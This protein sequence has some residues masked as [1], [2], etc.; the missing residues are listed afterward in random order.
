MMTRIAYIFA[1]TALIIVTGF[2]QPVHA[3]GKEN[4]TV[5]YP[6]DTSRM[7]PDYM[8]AIA[9]ANP[10]ETSLKVELSTDRKKW[11][12]VEVPDQNTKLLAVSSA[13]KK[14]YCI[15]STGNGKTSKRILYK[16]R[17]Y[18]IY[19]NHQKGKWDIRQL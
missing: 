1:I 6:Q 18:K 13:T 2:M 5:I 7:I 8:N 15:I 16:N 9:L 12:T 19:W 4:Y 11:N 10:S 17:K 3:Q 14:C